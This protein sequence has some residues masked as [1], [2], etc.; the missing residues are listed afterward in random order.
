[1]DSLS[2]KKDMETNWGYHCSAGLK[3]PQENDLIVFK[4]PENKEGLLV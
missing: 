4:N 3:M 1:M 2:A